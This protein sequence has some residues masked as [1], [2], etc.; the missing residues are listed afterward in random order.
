MGGYAIGIIDK[1]TLGVS[2]LA[3]GV[4]LEGGMNGQTQ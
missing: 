3:S 4:F 2:L 1:S